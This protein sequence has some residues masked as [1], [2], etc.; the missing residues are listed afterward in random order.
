MKIRFIK[1]GLEDGGHFDRDTNVL[2]FTGRKLE[3]NA[4]LVDLNISRGIFC[5]LPKARW[6]SDISQVVST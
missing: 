1:L 2:M 6:V 4:A 3:D 5:I